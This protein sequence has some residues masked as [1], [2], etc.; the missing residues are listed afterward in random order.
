M[1]SNYF[2]LCNSYYIMYQKYY[3]RLVLHTFRVVTYIKNQILHTPKVVIFTSHSSKR[4]AI[5]INMMTAVIQGSL[6]VG[7]LTCQVVNLTSTESKHLFK[8]R[9]YTS[10]IYDSSIALS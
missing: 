7:F 6:E 3:N 10:N 2:L 5:L 9:I 1:D 8:R 4:P